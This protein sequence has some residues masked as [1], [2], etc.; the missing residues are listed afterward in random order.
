MID[1]LLQDREAPD[2]RVVARLAAGD[3]GDADQRAAAEHIGALQ[4][5]A[6]DDADRRLAAVAASGSQ[7]DWPGRSPS[8]ASN[9]PV[10]METVACAWAASGAGEGEKAE[11]ERALQPAGYAKHTNSLSCAVPAGESMPA[12]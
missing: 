10:S 1:L 4:R 9:C 3:G 12:R 11:R 2:R 5:Q 8:L 7:R 6:D